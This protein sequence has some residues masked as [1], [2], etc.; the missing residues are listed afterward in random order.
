[1]LI[2]ILFIQYRSNGS[3]PVVLCG[4][5]CTELYC[6][7]IYCSVLYGIMLGLVTT[8]ISVE[9]IIRA[10]YRYLKYGIMSYHSMRW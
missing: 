5:D 10:K 7:E 3:N 1:M 9:L 4:M 2:I 6:P 8:I